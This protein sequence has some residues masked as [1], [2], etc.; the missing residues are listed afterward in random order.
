MTHGQTGVV[1]LGE[2]G[3][4]RGAH[5]LV[6]RGVREAEPG[7]A[8]AVIGSHRDLRAQLRAWCTA[9][10]HR[11]VV[12][13]DRLTVVVGRT[14]GSRWVGAVAG[15]APGVGEVVERPPAD[16]GLAARGVWVE[17]GG[18][19]P[20]FDLDHRDEIWSDDAARLYERALSGQWDPATAIPWDAPAHQDPAIERAVVQIMTYLVENEEAA[21]VVPARFLGRIH[22]HFAE[23]QHLLAV[24]VADEARHA[25]VFARRARLHDQ[26]P[27]LSGAGGRA[28]LQTLL[29]EADFA[30]AA[31]LL[32]VLGEGTFLALLGYIER[33]APDAT[34]AE[35]ARLV[36]IDEA[37]HV[38][39][40][41]SHLARHCQLDQHLRPRLAA[42]IERRHDDLRA[43]AGL[44]QDVLDALVILAAGE[45]TPSAIGR[46]W[47]AVQGL[48]ADMQD[49][50]AARLAKLGFHPEQAHQLATLHTRNFM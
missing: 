31:F 24:Q 18:P 6:D 32:S 23:I 39:F 22:P 26:P 5:V 2:L 1:L 43:T 14:V 49:G 20:R 19:S 41:I 46:G 21:L 16:W 28:S 8:I 47:D 30:T 15:G 13:G 44:N 33:H 3:F 34:T 12:E 48:Q 45:L 40:G 7:A 50:R 36:R 27:V 11:L 10:G 42:A 35:I 17:A 25:H 4:D 29:D 38:A 37:R 9:N